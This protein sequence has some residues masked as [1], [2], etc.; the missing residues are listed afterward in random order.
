M[1]L[2][3]RR[4]V[5]LIIL[6]LTEISQAT[7]EGSLITTSRLLNGQTSC[8]IDTVPDPMVP[9]FVYYYGFAGAMRSTRFLNNWWCFV[10]STVTVDNPMFTPDAS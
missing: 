2:K 3:V 9:E 6:A 10:L 8:N 7:K 1:Q 5:L 4:L